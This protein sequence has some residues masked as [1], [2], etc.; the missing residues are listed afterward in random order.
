MAA[1]TLGRNQFHVERKFVGR[2]VN[3]VAQD[4]FFLYRMKDRVKLSYT[5]AKAFWRRL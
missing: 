3:R 2:G 1:E 5:T 4:N